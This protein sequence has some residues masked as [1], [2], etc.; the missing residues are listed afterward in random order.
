MCR[1][2]LARALRQLAGELLAD[3]LLLRGLIMIDEFPGLELAGS[4]ADDLLHDRELVLVDRLVA[5]RC[6]KLVG[7]A[8]PSGKRSALTSKPLP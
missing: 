3:Q 5:N 4:P 8:D 6:E 7:G 1:L 2:A